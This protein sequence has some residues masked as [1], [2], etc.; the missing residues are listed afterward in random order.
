MV[1]PEIDEGSLGILAQVY[2]VLLLALA[3]ESG[4]IERL[5]LERRPRQR[6][7]P[8]HG[9][10]FWT[11]RRVRWFTLLVF[12][13]LV[14]DTIADVLTLTHVLPYTPV[15]TPVLLAGV[16]LALL[17]LATRVSIDVLEATREDCDALLPPRDAS[18]S[19]RVTPQASTAR[20]PSG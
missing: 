15:T 9:V 16:L 13:L 19:V 4:F 3:F 7:D 5:R 10:R 17:T 20:R 12:N 8:I 11:K 14:F 18:R 6:D 2:P 1:T